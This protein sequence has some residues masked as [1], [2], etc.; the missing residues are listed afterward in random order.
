MEE[1][2]IQSEFAITQPHNCQILHLLAAA[3]NEQP[4]A[5][6]ELEEIRD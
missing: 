2:L 4:S 3:Q 5:Q 1:A 6:I